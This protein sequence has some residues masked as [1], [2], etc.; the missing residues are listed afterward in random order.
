MKYLKTFENIS[1][2]ELDSLVEYF[3]DLDLDFDCDISGNRGLTSRSSTTDGRT[4]IFIIEI[5]FDRPEEIKAS[6]IFPEILNRI[7]RLKSIGE[8]DVYTFPNSSHLG[9]LR[10]DWVGGLFYESDNKYIGLTKEILSNPKFIGDRIES[11]IKKITGWREPPYQPER[12]YQ[13]SINSI[14]LYFSIIA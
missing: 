14:S 4:A 10:F 5:K 12:G 1:D 9:T 8:F 6:Q 7:N 2:P 3:S 13:Y 11:Q